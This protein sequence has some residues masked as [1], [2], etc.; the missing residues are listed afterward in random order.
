MDERELDENLETSATE[1]ENKSAISADLIRGH[2][3]TI[4]LRT[5]Y[6]RDK[7]DQ[8]DHQSPRE[9]VAAH[10]HPSLPKFSIVSR[11]NQT[12][13]EMMPAIGSMTDSSTA[14]ITMDSSATSDGSMIET[15]PAMPSSTSSS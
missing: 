1:D 2:I 14:P 8:R 5:L 13:L 10:S 12:M 11:D 9:A 4:I 15:R 6:E 3:N 7:Y